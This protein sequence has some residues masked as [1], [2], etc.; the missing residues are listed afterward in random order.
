MHNRELY[1]SKQSTST[2][3]QIAIQL[4][5]VTHHLLTEQHAARLYMNAVLSVA[6]A[7]AFGV[8]HAAI[9]A[10]LCELAHLHTP[11]KTP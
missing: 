1:V 3:R 2:S 7:V 10:Q 6:D 11:A 8:V 5:M 9:G 4:V